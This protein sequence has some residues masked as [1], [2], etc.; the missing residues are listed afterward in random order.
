[1][2]RVRAN[3]HD[4]AEAMRLLT[5][6]GKDALAKAEAKR[7][8]AEVQAIVKMQLARRVQGVVPKR[9]AE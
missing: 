2:K 8:S 7:A 6:H 1:M 3:L 4:Y 9:V 5:A